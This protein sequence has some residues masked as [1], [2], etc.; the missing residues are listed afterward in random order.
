MEDVGAYN[1]VQ[2][3]LER[4]TGQ[5][6]DTW[7]KSI[8]G[9]GR[10]NALLYVP[11]RAGRPLWLQDLRRMYISYFHIITQVTALRQECN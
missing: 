6:W 9:E 3:R 7:E 4:V 10:A 1:M 8:P 2:V 11:G 5:A